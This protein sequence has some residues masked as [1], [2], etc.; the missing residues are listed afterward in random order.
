MRATWWE[1]VLLIPV[2]RTE[3]TANVVHQRAFDESN[4]YV[5]LTGLL[6]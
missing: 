3:R 2:K 6:E 1:T 4:R 5:D